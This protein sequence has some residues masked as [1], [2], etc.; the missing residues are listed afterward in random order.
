MKLICLIVFA[1]LAGAQTSNYPGS[2]DTD[3]TLF[4]TSDNVQS[5][6]SQAMATG[7]NV[8]FVAS[9]TGFQPNML[10]TICE[11]TVT[12]GKCTSWEHM[13]ITAVNGQAL[14]VM[15]GQ[16]GTSA[17]THAVGRFVSAL[18]DSAHQSSLKSAAIGIETTL[19]PN[20]TNITNLQ[21][22]ITTGSVTSIL[23]GIHANYN[24]LPVTAE[25]QNNTR[26]TI[27][28]LVG[29][30]AT[31]PTNVIMNKGGVRALVAGVSGYAQCTRTDVDCVGVYSWATATTAGATSIWGANPGITNAPTPLSMDGSGVALQ[32][33]IGEE[34]D[35]NVFTDGSGTPPV[36]VMG[37]FITGAST[38]C[39]SGLCAA[40]LVNPLG[41]F[42]TPVVPW[43][44][45]FDSEP[46][47]ATVGLRLWP[48]A[49]GSNQQSQA[50]YL[51]ASNASGTTQTS[52]IFTDPI[53]T[54][55]LT[56]A[57]GNVHM[58]G[59]GLFLDNP[60]GPVVSLGSESVSSAPYIQFFNGT[61][62][63]Q[64][65]I[66]LVAGTGTT[67]NTGTLSIGAGKLQAG[68]WTSAN[69]SVATT[70]TSLGPT[71]AATTVQG[72]LHIVV[73]GVDHFVPYW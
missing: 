2:I 8:A 42:Q 11:V 1:A 15:R 23:N 24:G 16:A 38:H 57:N 41:E 4:V 52:S 44:T 22:S 61:S 10:I 43:T 3:T 72:W 67:V 73:S 21:R 34:V 70:L 7:D 71:G 60:S 28:S 18:I 63:V 9:G 39:G 12:G 55:T 25:D 68:G 50:I 6:L 62:T 47:A 48:V 45:A 59:Q 37:V 58:T 51:N 40:V 36:N 30:A 33:M 20:L 53:G 19:G 49:R 14:T 27:Q 66:T 46:G 5:T 69:G 13:L 26:S 56:G 35:V 54:L 17:Q 31:P 32:S 65:N 29:A 64:A